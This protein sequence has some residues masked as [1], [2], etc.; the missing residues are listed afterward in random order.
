MEDYDL[1]GR[2]SYSRYGKEQHGSEQKYAVKQKGDSFLIR[3]ETSRHQS[4]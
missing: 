3:K 1:D 4:R 2:R